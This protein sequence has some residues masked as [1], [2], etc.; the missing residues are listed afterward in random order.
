MHGK[1]DEIGD[2]KSNITL[3][4][5]LH[6]PLKQKVTSGELTLMEQTEGILAHESNIR[7]R[8]TSS[9]HL[10]CWKWNLH[11]ITPSWST[12]PSASNSNAWAY[13]HSRGQRTMSKRQLLLVSKIT[14]VDQVDLCFSLPHN[15]L[16][17]AP[18]ADA[19]EEAVLL[20]PCHC[21]HQHL[22]QHHE[23]KHLEESERLAR[24]QPMSTTKNMQSLSHH[25]LAIVDFKDSKSSSTAQR[26][27][28][29]RCPVLTAI[30]P[31]AS[32]CRALQPQ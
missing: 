12:L 4:V 29:I 20:S 15:D 7:A 18:F 27:S 28:S 11:E 30:H 8:L 9:K 17:P 31:V 26:S 21:A 3:L 24:I 10:M 19:V 6:C 5:A 2:Q 1:V 25:S 16:V 22:G 13:F 14:Q 23:M 32:R